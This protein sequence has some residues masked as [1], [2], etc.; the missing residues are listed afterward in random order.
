[1]RC[2]NATYVALKSKALRKT[3]NVRNNLKNVNR[4]EIN[5]VQLAECGKGT[6]CNAIMASY[7]AFVRLPLKVISGDFIKIGNQALVVTCFDCD[8]TNTREAE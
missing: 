2:H 5:R 8:E 4:Y 1:M 3:V 7:V 6:C